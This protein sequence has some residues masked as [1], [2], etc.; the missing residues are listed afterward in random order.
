VLV[1]PQ[2]RAMETC[3][4]IG[5]HHDAQVCDELVEWDYGDYEGLTDEET[6]EHHPGWNVFCDGCPGGESPGQVRTRVERVLEMVRPLDGPCLLISHGKLLRALTARWLDGDIALGNVLP[7][8]PAAISLLEREAGRPLLR[9]WN[10]APSLVRADSL[11]E[12]AT[13]AV[14]ADQAGL[15]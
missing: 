12:A 6:Q 8:D 5:H 2:I 13:A 3:R 15:P 11:L 1:S 14:G 9:L 4:M 10:L 7:L